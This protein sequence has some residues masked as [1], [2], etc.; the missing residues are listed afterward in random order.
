MKSETKTR[1]SSLEQVAV[2]VKTGEFPLEFLSFAAAAIWYKKVCV[3]DMN[4]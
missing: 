4:S 3:W 2:T 1:S